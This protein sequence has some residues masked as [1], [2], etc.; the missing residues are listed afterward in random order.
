M[1]CELYL[2]IAIFKCLLGTSLVLQWQR[3]H[4]PNVGSPGSIPGQ[5]TTSHM[6]QLKIPRVSTRTQHDQN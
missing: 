6:Q 3:L 1:V 2:N 5:G 4:T